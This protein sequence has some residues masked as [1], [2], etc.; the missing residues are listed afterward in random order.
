MP[1]RVP[2]KNPVVL[3]GTNVQSGTPNTGQVLFTLGGSK[4]YTRFSGG[5]AD[6][7]IHLGAGRL[8]SYQLHT[9][10]ALNVASGVVAYLY[11]GAVA[12]AGVAA[13]SG[14]KVLGIADPQAIPRPPFG[15]FQSGDK[16]TAG[17]VI[18]VGA[19]F[20]SGLNISCLSGGGGITVI[21]TPVVSG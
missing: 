6:V 10:T 2:T 17:P 9:A 5:A 15:T 3:A 12:G 1:E 19:P 20:A 13:A 14:H 21:Y 18:Q 7:Q 16:I 4:A 11:D 8:D